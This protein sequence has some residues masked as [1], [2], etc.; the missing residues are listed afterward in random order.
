MKQA[1][2]LLSIALFCKM[3]GDRILDL[4]ISEIIFSDYFTFPDT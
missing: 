3:F 1:P 2:N 4:K